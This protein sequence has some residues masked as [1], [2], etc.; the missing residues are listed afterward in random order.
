MS[1]DEV[2]IPDG[3][4][5]FPISKIK[6]FDKNARN[7]SEEQIEQIKNS[8]IE[9]GFLNP[10]L[11]D[12][13]GSVIAGHGRLMAANRLGL[14]DVPVIVLK[15][16]SDAQKRAYCI[17]DNAIALN[18]EWD[19]ELLKAEMVGLRALNIDL[20]NLGFSDN[21]LDDFFKEPEPKKEK[22]PKP[23]PTPTAG[24]PINE[25]ERKI[26]PGI[27]EA[28]AALP[29][30]PNPDIPDQKLKREL[31]PSETQQG[32]KALPSMKG[33]PVSRIGD[34]WLL[35]KHE[36][37]CARVMDLSIDKIVLHWQELTGKDAVL[38]KNKKSFT[39][40]GISRNKK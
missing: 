10:I 28:P 40:T 16:L 36:V 17:A 34:V 24:K 3:A 26:L 22:K 32:P 13:K 14:E 31:H 18:S 35:G 33:N 4:T 23:V 19:D 21:E 39:D 1:G 8:M 38:K 11:I 2:K 37:K 20:T 29:K 6:P 15:H 25:P 7:H 27:V 9:F 30:P 12:E 5:L